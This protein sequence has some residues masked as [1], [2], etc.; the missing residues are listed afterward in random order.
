MLAMRC[1]CEFR[2]GDGL[3]GKGFYV[4]DDP[5]NLTAYKPE[6]LLDVGYVGL[7]TDLTHERGAN[8]NN[9]PAVGTVDVVHS[10]IPFAQRI[11][12]LNGPHGLAQ[13]NF[14]VREHAKDTV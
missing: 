4:V 12:W 9:L 2:P 3:Y 5:W 6:V 8:R 11:Y 10:N 14:R 7:P 1:S 13:Q